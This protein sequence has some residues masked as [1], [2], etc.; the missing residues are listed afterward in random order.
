MK[1]TYLSDSGDH[2]DDDSSGVVRSLRLEESVWTDDITE[3]DTDKDESGSDL[4]ISES[5]LRQNQDTYHLLGISTNV[6]S[7]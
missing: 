6:S 7:D 1:Q 2:A 4:D 5:V 3:S